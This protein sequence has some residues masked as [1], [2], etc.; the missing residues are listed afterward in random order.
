M[1]HIPIIF[2]FHFLNFKYIF[3]CKLILMDASYIVDDFHFFWSFISCQRFGIDRTWGFNW[4]GSLY[5]S[6]PHV[7]LCQSLRCM[8]FDPYWLHALF[9]IFPH[10]IPLCNLIMIFDQFSVL[11]IVG[12]SEFRKGVP[13]VYK[14]NDIYKKE[15]RKSE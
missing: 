14:L 6:L 11:E 5:G 9:F 7:W 4:L 8:K 13:I 10:L 15:N 1:S 2:G 3:R 12:W